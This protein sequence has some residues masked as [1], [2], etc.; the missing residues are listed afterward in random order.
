[1]YFFLFGQKSYYLGL[2]DVRL[3]YQSQYA[4]MKYP[5]FVS[6]ELIINFLYDRC[7]IHNPCCSKIGDEDVLDLLFYRATRKLTDLGI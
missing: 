3:N 7:C 6:I 5:E 2:F 1:M 4:F